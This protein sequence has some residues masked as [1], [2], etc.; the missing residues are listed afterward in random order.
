MKEFDRMCKLHHK[1]VG[2]YLVSLFDP[3]LSPRSYGKLS[4]TKPYHANF[5]KSS[6]TPSNLVE[7]ISQQNI[8]ISPHLHGKGFDLMKKM[9]YIGD[10][11]LGKG[12]GIIEPPVAQYRSNR[13]KT[14][15]R[16]GEQD[17]TKT[18]SKAH[19]KHSESSSSTLVWV[20][21]QKGD[22]S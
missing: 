9:G 5:I 16:Y 19:L 18:S 4:S 11:P 3:P 7:E 6:G 8:D 10:G 15:V 22:Y 12:R 13:S 21:K 14:G 20:P 2:E 17:K 1:G